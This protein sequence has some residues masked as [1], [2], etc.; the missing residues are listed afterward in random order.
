MILPFSGVV[1]NHAQTLAGPGTAQVVPEAQYHTEVV[2]LTGGAGAYAIVLTAAGL[3]AGAHV[4]LNLQ[5]P[6]TPNLDVTVYNQATGN[7]NALT[8]V[9]TDGSGLPATLVY[10]FDGNN[11]KPI[12]V[13]LPA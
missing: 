5:L 8:V 13:K 6:A 10:F 1:G 7:P 9:A 2:A 11:F 3:V 4:N 12:L